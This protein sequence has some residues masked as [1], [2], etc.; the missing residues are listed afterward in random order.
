MNKGKTIIN[1]S[2]SLNANSFTEHYRIQGEAYDTILSIIKKFAERVEK[3]SDNEKFYHEH[4]S[5]FVIGERGSGKTTFLLSIRDFIEGSLNNGAR[6][7]DIIDP[8]IMHDSD[9]FIS[10]VLGRINEL[11]SKE[12][13]KRELYNSFI[14][15]FNKVASIITAISQAKESVGLDNILDEQNALQLEH[16][17]HILL[18]DAKEC[19]GCKFF[20]L[21]ID[22]IDIAFKH[23][24]EVLERI[25]KYLSSPY[26]LPILSGNIDLYE[27]I[28]AGKFYNQLTKDVASGIK[29]FEE[30]SNWLQGKEDNKGFVGRSL[31]LSNFYLDKVLPRNRRILLKELN[32]LDKSNIL[33][34]FENL[35]ENLSLEE[36]E[37]RIT[38]IFNSGLG[39]Y[40]ERLIC[41]FPTANLRS[42]IQF[43]SVVEKFLPYTSYDFSLE[44]IKEFYN[45]IANF[46]KFA[47]KEEQ[48][49]KH[50]AL[51]N[52][53]SRSENNKFSVKKFSQD[54]V[55]NTFV[56]EKMDKYIQ[57]RKRLVPFCAKDI[58]FTNP[59]S[60]IEKLFYI[61]SFE[62]GINNGVRIYIS[63][64]KLFLW[65]TAKLFSPQD[66]EERDKNA[67]YSFGFD[68]V[69]FNYDRSNDEDVSENDIRS[70]EREAYE[71]I[72]YQ[73]KYDHLEIEFHI[74]S[75]YINNIV[76]NCS[77]QLIWAMY[78]KYRENVN[79]I[80]AEINNRKP[81]DKNDKSIKKENFSTF[82][83]R[84]IYA[85]VNALAI[86]TI[87]NNRFT[88]NNIC[89]EIPLDNSKKNEIERYLS[90]HDLA[91]RWNIKGWDNDSDNFENIITQI[92]DALLSIVD[93]EDI[94]I[95][96]S[97]QAKTSTSYDKGQKKNSTNYNKEQKLQITK[98]IMEL[99]NSSVSTKEFIQE[100]KT[101]INYDEVEKFWG[102][103][104][105]LKKTRKR[106]DND[107]IF[108]AVFGNFIEK[109]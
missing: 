49:I 25:R 29:I 44:D 57:P 37:K 60:N 28:F 36:I 3:V 108:D 23:G 72:K 81:N 74:K 88:T 13:K 105:W 97:L 101:F 10:I 82:V 51:V 94:D 42:F 11:V 48:V 43:L 38:E 35:E 96:I 50:F 70:S 75:E 32:D 68:N 62:E 12:Y 102:L 16:Q 39:G 98:R 103:K 5:I 84:L 73:K 45:K 55:F 91:Y 67:I 22:D 63:P 54:E 100:L 92:L 24:F 34:E 8:T 40:S 15:S 20:I 99:K 33:I 86:A 66:F 77:C 107:I 104:M 30:K 61:I 76:P 21:P 93:K 46:Y 69:L 18:R 79:A 80:L 14:N 52:S 6:F 17:I 83:T 31:S 4:N 87:K 106:I 95:T 71:R 90:Q 9:N 109:K 65:L 7:L 56:E 41:P 59:Q 27:Q 19:I 53:K 47:N 58:K 1:I 2:E 64:D 78:C 26:I 89:I 85:Y